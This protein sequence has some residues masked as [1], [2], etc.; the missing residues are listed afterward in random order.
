M[1]IPNWM[2]IAIALLFPCAA[3]AAGLSW[4]Q[5]ALHLGV[6]LLIFLLGYLLFA[7]NILGGGDVKVIAAVAVWTGGS[8]LIPFT[9]A[10][11]IAGGALA[12]ILLGARKLATPGPNHP[13]YLN[14]LLDPSRGAPYAIAIAAGAYFSLP[15]QPIFR[16]LFS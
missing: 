14:R 8:A 15:A 16:A 1:N 9:Y 13:A 12:L 3:I 2:S 7:L 10:M 6:G 11:C 4:T 5:I